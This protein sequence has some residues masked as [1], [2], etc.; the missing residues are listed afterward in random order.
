TCL[1][2]IAIRFCVSITFSP[3]SNLSIAFGSSR[4]ARLLY[5]SR[6]MV[7]T[8][9]ARTGLGRARTRRTAPRP[10]AQKAVGRI[11][12]RI[13][14]RRVVRRA[15]RA[16]NDLNEDLSAKSPVRIADALSHWPQPHASGTG[17]RQGSK[18]VDW[19]PQR[20]DARG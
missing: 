3:C 1:L 15:G 17:Q 16:R 13:P 5:Q 2:G 20:G 7:K 9:W 11:L 12:K 14:P 10:A 4:P 18:P 8:P 6:R 19:R